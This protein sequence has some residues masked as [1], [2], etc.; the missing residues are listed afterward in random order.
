MVDTFQ[1]IHKYFTKCVKYVNT[2]ISLMLIRLNEQQILQIVFQMFVDSEGNE[3]N[4][5]S[6]DQ[7]FIFCHSRKALDFR[8]VIRAQPRLTLPSYQC[9][10]MEWYNIFEVC[11]VRLEI[12]FIMFS[13]VCHIY[14]FWSLSSISDRSVGLGHGFARAW[15]HIV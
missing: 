4:S 8:E 3:V 1:E 12:T 11:V 10:I 2:Y 5:P 7:L 6:D 13:S 15:A 9:H 14:I